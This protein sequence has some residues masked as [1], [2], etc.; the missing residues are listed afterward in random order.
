M[1]SKHLFRGVASQ[2]GFIFIYD[3][4]RLV[5]TRSLRQLRRYIT[6]FRIFAL[7][8]YES[9][10]LERNLSTTNIVRHVFVRPEFP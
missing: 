10:G 7:Q 3:I 6:S 5:P 8:C 4:V 1:G 9:N 2:V